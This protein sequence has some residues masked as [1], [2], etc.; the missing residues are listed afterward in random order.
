MK[1]DEI[2]TMLEIILPNEHEAYEIGRA[3]VYAEVL[4]LPCKSMS[5]DDVEIVEKIEKVDY[6]VCGEPVGK[7][8]RVFFLAEA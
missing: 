8:Y 4:R 1:F 2:I 6:L 5:I 7:L 3:A